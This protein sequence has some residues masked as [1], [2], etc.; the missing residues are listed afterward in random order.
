MV[1]SSAGYFCQQIRAPKVRTM[2]RNFEET[3]LVIAKVSIAKIGV[4]DKHRYNTQ[5]A[6]LINNS[7]IVL[8]AHAKQH[9]SQ[10][11]TK[12]LLLQEQITF[13]DASATTLTSGINILVEKII[14]YTI[15][16]PIVHFVKEVGALSDDKHD[17][18]L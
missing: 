4:A 5:K 11:V 17:E 10:Q 18:E 14:C 3:L 1:I 12:T 8:H 16:V 13:V 15:L 2:K 6:S 9:N 7:T